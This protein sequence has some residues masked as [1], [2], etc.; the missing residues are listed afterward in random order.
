M[1]AVYLVVDQRQREQVQSQEPGDNLQKPSPG[2]LLLQAM[3]QFLTVVKP[4]P[5][6]LLF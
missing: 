6:A 3:P 1:V 5:T 2:G 4:P